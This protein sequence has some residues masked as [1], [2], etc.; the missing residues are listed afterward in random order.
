MREVLKKY[1]MDD[2][3]P[4][5]TPILQIVKQDGDINGAKTDETA[6]RGMVGSLMYLTA[7][8]LDIVFAVSLA[9]RFQSDLRMLQI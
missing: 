3:K 6:Y 4:L 2:A 1:H 5:A 8:R 7:S 9:A